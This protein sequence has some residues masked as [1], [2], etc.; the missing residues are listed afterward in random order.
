MTRKQI[1]SVAVVILSTF[2]L[3]TL[4]VATMPF[5]LSASLVM[6]ELIEPLKDYIVKGFMREASKMMFR[7]FH[8]P[9]QP[10]GVV[11]DK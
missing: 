8:S 2:M 4:L 11:K 9:T 6:P 7:G 5:W 1:I 10:I 3:A